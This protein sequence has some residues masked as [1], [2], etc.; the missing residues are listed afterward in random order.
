[1]ALATH[2]C[3]WEFPPCAT[4][5]AGD[6]FF[7]ELFMQNPVKSYCPKKCFRHSLKKIATLAFSWRFFSS[8]SN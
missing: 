3:D 7:A 2:V 8:G 1:M 5:D 4:T 6:F